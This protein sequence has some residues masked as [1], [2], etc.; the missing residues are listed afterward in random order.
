MRYRKASTALQRV[1]AKLCTSC[2]VTSALDGTVTKQFVAP[3]ANPITSSADGRLFGGCIL[4]GDGS[5]ELD[6]ELTLP[7]RPIVV[8]SEEN[9]VPVGFPRNVAD[10]RRIAFRWAEV[11]PCR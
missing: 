4:F 10:G 2:A 3:G 1:L 7:P 6:P 5:L 11:E 9:L 8:A